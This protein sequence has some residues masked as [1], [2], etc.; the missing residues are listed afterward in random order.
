MAEHLSME[1]LARLVDG[2]PSPTERAH[3]ASCSACAAELRALRDQTE[4]LTALP[5]L[6]PPRG[7]WEEVEARFHAE[8]LIRT[9]G[10]FRTEVPSRAG[11]PTRT[12]AP[13]RAEGRA[14]GGRPRARWSVPSSGWLPAAAAVV[15]FLGGGVTGAALAGESDAGDPADASARPTATVAEAAEAV[16]T[17]EERYIEAFLLYRELSGE[18]GDDGG[19]DPSARYAALDALL[20]A[21]RQAVREAPAD[22]FLNGVLVSTLAERQATLRRISTDDGEWY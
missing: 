17:A 22:P 21:S 8:G 20:T 14:G 10:P 19:R 13:V 18:D 12:G 1:T 11:D 3:V 2:P 16:R 4:A 15:L 6:R 5:V 7:E 9:E